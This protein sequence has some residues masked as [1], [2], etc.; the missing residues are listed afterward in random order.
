MPKGRFSSNSLESIIKISKISATR[1]R[2]EQIYQPEEENREASE[3]IGEER[4]CHP[5][6][7]DRFGQLLETY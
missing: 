4:G 6:G 3:R 7:S 1:D 5:A 2:E